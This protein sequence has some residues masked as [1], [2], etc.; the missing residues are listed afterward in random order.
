MKIRI[1]YLIGAIDKNKRYHDTDYLKIFLNQD[2]EVPSI[3]LEN[4]DNNEQ[5]ILEELHKKHLKYDFD[6]Y[7]KTLCGFRILDKDICEICYLIIVKHIGGVEINGSFYTL[8]QIQE[9][10]ILLEE[11]YGELFFRFGQTSIR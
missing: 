5:E 8:E 2:Y 6:F 4:F 3:T 7:P 1:C 11:Y 9:Q 10:N